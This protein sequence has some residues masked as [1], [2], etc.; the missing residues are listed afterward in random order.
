[1]N[2]N[3]QLYGIEM[4]SGAAKLD[5]DEASFH[6]I[7]LTEGHAVLT[8]GEDTL[9]LE[10]GASVFLPAGL[11]TYTLDGTGQAILTTV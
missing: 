4:S 10:K 5:A 9:T 3:V 11:G 8:A 1:M 6:H 2:P 7:L